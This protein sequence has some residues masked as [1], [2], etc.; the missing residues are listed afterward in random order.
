MIN[1]TEQIDSVNRSVAG[2]MRAQTPTRTVTISQ[3]YD[4]DVADLWDACTNPERIPRWFLPVS[5]QLRVGGRYQLEGNAGGVIEECE[6]PH[7]FVAT[8]EF[9][10]AVTWIDVRCIAEASDRT[11]LEIAHI[12]R[13]DDPTWTEFGPGAVG[14]GWD[15]ALTGLVLHLA[16]SGAPVDPA[17]AAT[18]MASDEGQ[19]FVALSSERWREAHTAGGTPEAEADAAAAR[20]RVAYGATSER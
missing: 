18:W 16:S 12:S 11:R 4:T 3:T 13:A 10:D 6:P 1:V 9:R 5:G 14:I 19:R 8:W 7:R 20:V 2:G 15:M 17:A